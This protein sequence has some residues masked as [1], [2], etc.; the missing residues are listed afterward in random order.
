M[1]ETKHTPGPWT[2]DEVGKGFSAHILGAPFGGLQEIV[3]TLYVGEET[4]DA[5]ARLIAAAPDMLAVL[6][7]LCSFNPPPTQDDWDEARE[8][9]AKAEAGQ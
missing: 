6:K 5:N 3:A 1:T 7:W 2:I 8:I 4:L 9:V